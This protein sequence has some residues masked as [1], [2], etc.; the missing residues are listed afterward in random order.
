MNGYEIAAIVLASALAIFLVYSLTVVKKVAQ[1]VQSVTE[2]I[3]TLADQV[4]D[5]VEH[6]TELV[7][8]VNSKLEKTDP[9]FE[10]IGDVGESV[11]DVNDSTRQ[12][13]GK[14]AEGAKS[15]KEKQ[16]AVVSKFIKIGKSK[17]KK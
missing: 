15:A 4:G 6:T 8:D 2:D 10:A 1:A 17:L 12:L 9:L 3:D 14:V 13:V 7:K 16:S 5:L 11:S